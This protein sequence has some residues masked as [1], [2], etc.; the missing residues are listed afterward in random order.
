MSDS[1]YWK[2]LWEMADWLAKRKHFSNIRL[3]DFVAI[4]FDAMNIHFRLRRTEGGQKT[5]YWKKP[6]EK[7]YNSYSYRDQTLLLKDLE[8]IEKR[9][10]G[11]EERKLF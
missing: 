9:A 3:D 11:Y 7:T 10:K 4:E 2:N 6:N 5:L 8:E 1:W